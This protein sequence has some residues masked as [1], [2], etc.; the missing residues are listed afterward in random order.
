MAMAAAFLILLIATPAVRAVQHTVG[1][2][3][4]WSQSTDFPTWASGKTFTVGDKLLFTYGGT[5]SVDIVSENDYNNCNAGSPINSYNNGKTTINLDK[6]GPM[7]FM[8]PTFGH[9]QNG[10]KLAITVMAATTPTTPTTGTPPAAISPPTDSSTSPPST[11]SD[12]PSTTP[13]S[14]PPPPSGAS[15]IFGGMGN[16][17]L[18]FSLFV[19]AMIVFVG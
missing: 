18:G 6:A 19:T 15:R 7:Y 10:M 5:H 8:C 16:V 9:C 13:T 3:N 12:T 1:D 14:S 4:G 11:S 2:S 17:M